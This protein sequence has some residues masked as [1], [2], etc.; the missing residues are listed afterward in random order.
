MFCRHH[1][2]QLTFPCHQVSLHIPRR[3]S[4]E[5]R[6][7]LEEDHL[8]LE[9][10]AITLSGSRVA[11]Q[12]LIVECVRSGVPSEEW[13]TVQWAG[14]I[15]VKDG[16]PVPVKGRFVG[17]WAHLRLPWTRGVRNSCQVNHPCPATPTPRHLPSLCKCRTGH[18]DRSLCTC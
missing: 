15:L 8:Q 12:Y 17:A 6:D 16:V 1:V 3:E 18:A 11:H 10:G 5:D 9:G 7:S 4:D 2:F 13:P 14:R